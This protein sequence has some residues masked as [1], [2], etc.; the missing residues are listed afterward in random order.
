MKKL[1]TLVMVLAFAG[2]LFAQITMSG[3]ARV[4]PRYDAKSDGDYGG[5]SADVYYMYRAR[6]NLAANVGDGWFFKTQL[7]TNGFAWWTG[8]FGTGVTPSTSSVDGA[9]RG[10][11]SFMQLYFGVKKDNWGFQGGLIPLNS[12]KNPMLDLHY[13]PGK[14]LDI[15]FLIYSN[16]AAHGFAGYFKAGP[17]K[18]DVTVIVDNNSGSYIEDIN[19]DEVSSEKDQYMIM[20]DYAMKFAGIGIQ[21]VF[22]YTMAGLDTLAAP[23][24][25]GVNITAPKI[26][27]FTPSINVGMTQQTV[28]E[29]GEYNGWFFRAKIAG[30]V[31]P[32]SLAAWFD[33]AQKT[34]VAAV[35]DDLVHDFKYIWLSYK[36]TVHKGEYGQVTVAPT[37]RTYMYS[38]EDTKDY[39]RHKIEITTEIKFK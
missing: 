22:M 28:K 16:M 33:M 15:P 23:M 34:D 19:G 37:W 3:D 29:A 1:L 11:I 9:G 18:L 5:S 14:M 35:G 38:I 12:L 30:K 27:G 10:S 13:Y 8:K 4:R 20:L 24:T 17:G 7:G 36:Y 26:A 32:G 2:G 25:F 21:P 31:G 6:L 39:V